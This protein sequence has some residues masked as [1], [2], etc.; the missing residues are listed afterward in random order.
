[1]STAVRLPASRSL[2]DLRIGGGVQSGTRQRGPILVSGSHRS[3]T[4]WVGKIL[5][6]APGSFYL[7]EPFK[8]EFAASDNWVRLK[9]YFSYLD[10]ETAGQYEGQIAR[11]LESHFNWKRHYRISDG[12]SQGWMGARSWMRCTCNRLLHRRAIMKDPIALFSAAWLAQRFDMSVIIMIRHPA[13]FVSSI[14]LKKWWFNFRNW[15]EQPKLCEGLLRPF[16]DE[17]NRLADR[18]E[19][20]VDQ[21]ILQWRAFHHVIRGYR[22][23][24][25][26][27]QFIWHEELSRD[28]V[29]CFQRMFRSAGLAFTEKS[30]QAVMI[31]TAADNLSDAN[32]AGMSTR[33]TNLNSV[34]SL[35]NWKTRL[36]SDEIRH[37]REG[38]ADVAQYFYTDAD[39]E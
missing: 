25:P 11:T 20:I 37:I 32:A 28:P 8:P 26:E 22:L 5:S 16:A 33:F 38:T 29:P 4:T 10:P 13:A 19:D 18:N 9:H 23:Q 17:I 36:S 21:A 14:K 35:H 12:W 24:H 7:H 2:P 34:A 6:T 30:R 1:M 27:W 39:W 31:S 15:T 3:G